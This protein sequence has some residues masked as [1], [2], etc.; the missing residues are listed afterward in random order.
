ML[1]QWKDGSTTWNK[2]KDVKDSY[3]FQLAEFAIQQGFSDEPAFA[4]WIPF[5]I[6]KKERKISKIKSKYWSRTH[7]YGIRIPKSVPDAIQIDA[8]NRN[9]LWWQSLMQEMKNA[10][11]AFEIYEGDV[12]DLKDIKRSKCHI[13]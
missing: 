9:D 11:P 1:I 13:V 2:L 12:K 5:V 6:K 10:R 4:W 7:K 3:P 8:Q